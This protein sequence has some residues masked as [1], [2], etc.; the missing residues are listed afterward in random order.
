MTLF[1]AAICW[2]SCSHTIPQTNSGKLSHFRAEC[3]FCLIQ[4]VDVDFDDPF[5][6]DDDFEFECLRKSDGEASGISSEIPFQIDLPREFVDEH[7]TEL[8]S[9]LS[10]VCVRG[11]TIDDATVPGQVIIPEG[12]D[13]ELFPGAKE[14]DEDE[15]EGLGFG[16]RTVLVVRV[17][18]T[19]E[20]PVETLEELQGA[21]FGLGRQPLSNSMRAQFGRCSF[22]KI[23]FIPAS[24]F[25]QFDNGVL[26]IPLG[27]RLQGRGALGVMV[28]ATD[29][30]K[31]ILGVEFLR[32][33]F[34]HIIF[35]MARGTTYGGRSD[36]TAFATLN[37]WRSV[38]NSGRC[39]SLSYLMHEIGHNL[40]L[41]HSD[42]DAFIGDTYGDTTGMVSL[43]F[44][45]CLN[46]R[47]IMCLNHSCS[48]VCVLVWFCLHR[49]DSGECNCWFG[50]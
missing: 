4:A 33:S 49:W 23:E 17:L 38:F 14:T 27:Y 10:T 24:G 34:D 48:F 8:Q 9:G 7:A 41:V 5:S 12:A 25:E 39:D 32:G 15:D 26:N 1:Y 22:S 31:A 18:G 45:W 11:G 36:W 29:A 13:L 46:V 2:I 3:L 20:S 50:T 19:G 30:V 44:V 28:D 43:H 16:N 47:G 40:G 37:G 21:V 42:D 35:C 6:E